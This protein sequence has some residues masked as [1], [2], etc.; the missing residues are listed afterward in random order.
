M[1]T[2]AVEP[3]LI[4]SGGRVID[5]ASGIDTV[6]DVAVTAGRIA[7]IGR[8][9]AAAHPEVEVV[10]AHG[11]IVS[12]GLID[13]H[14]HIYPGLGSFCVAPDDAGVHRGV[15]II[16]DGG[17]SGT[18]TMRLAYDWIEASRPQTKV[19]SFMDPCTLYLATH[20]FICHKLEIANDERNIDVDA[21]A[22][23]FEALPEFIVGLKVRVCH[24]GD[25]TRSP[26]LDAAKSVAGAR[27]IMVHMGRFPHTPSIETPTMLDALR[28]GDIITHAFRGASGVLSLSD[29]QPI[30]EFR[31]AVERGVLLD[32][33]H[34]ATDFRFRDARRLVAAGYRPNTV[35]TDMNIFNI[36]GPVIS[37]HETMSK[38]LA[39]GF[40]LTDVVAMATTAPAAALHLS[41]RY[42]TLEVG[43]EAEISVFEMIEGEALLTDGYE[44]V[45]ADRRLVPIGCV[46]A[47][48]WIRATAGL[49]PQPV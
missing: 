47:G 6:A 26:F 30:A 35:S 14:V 9:L 36:D 40:D 37:L 38:M 10:D 17:T 34:S 25:P 11:C 39:L 21:I 42:G 20:D 31:D 4:I 1:A 12:P 46:R 41:D 7:A 19:L 16:V 18:A 22:A 3:D 5:P 15:P 33:G 44:T 29:G 27:P 8:G 13:L 2:P 43:R 24:T 28:P 23:M 48:E 49:L 32:I 45:A